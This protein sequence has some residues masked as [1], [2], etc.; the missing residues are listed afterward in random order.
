MWFPVSTFLK[1]V[2]HD[3]RNVETTTR[4]T[5]S[6]LEEFTQFVRS[7]LESYHY[8]LYAVVVIWTFLEGET[9]IIVLGYLAQEGNYNINIWLV[10]GF[11]LLGSFVGDQFY[12]YI[13]RIYGQPLLQRWPGMEKKIAWAF[14][15]VRDHQTIFILTFRFIYGV[16][17]ISPFVIGMSGVSRLKYFVLN[18]IAATV[19]ANS[20]AWGGYFLGVAMGEWLG[21]YKF[22]ILGGFVGLFVLL[23]FLSTMKRRKAQEVAIQAAENE[24]SKTHP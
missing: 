11:A 10:M 16:R 18:L 9:F 3:R 8:L 13:G 21:A 12:F 7:F 24:R 2:P 5:G 14:H 1:A 4:V 20:F 19:W 6:V 23:W 22:H 17:N 15:M